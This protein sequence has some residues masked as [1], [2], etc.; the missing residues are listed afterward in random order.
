M[1]ATGKAT[2][3]LS[4]QTLKRLWRGQFMRFV[5]VGGGATVL[6]Y[7]LLVVLVQTTPLAETAC[8]ALAFALSA[9]ANYLANYYFTFK[10]SRRHR[11]AFIRFVVT[12]CLGVVINSLTFYL[13]NQL[14]PHYLLAQIL[15]TGVTLVSNFLLHKF[16]IY[17]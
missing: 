8:S 17:R 1:Q 4:R 3:F 14:L 11:E 10:A 9:V 7:T 12:A 13:A 16:W 2:P 15:A 6:Q 5:M